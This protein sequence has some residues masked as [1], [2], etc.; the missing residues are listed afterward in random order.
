MSDILRLFI[1]LPLPDE[2]KAA[3]KTQQDFL[4]TQ[5][6]EHG[7]TIRWTT[8]EQWHLT[9]AFLGATNRERLLSIQSAMERA[10]KPIKAFR[11]ETTSLGAFPSPRRPSVVWLGVGGEVTSLQTLQRRLSEALSG[12]LEPDDKPF[13]PHLTLA[14]LKQFGLGAKVSEAF[15]QAPPTE[16]PNWTVNELCLYQSVLKPS[17]AE[18]V[19]QHRVPLATG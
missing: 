1:A 7:K 13:K 4:K 18:Y 19:V 2:V 12:M 3:L 11:L 9:L 10:A 17:G 6:Q 16:R 5:L 15:G 14:R 8:R